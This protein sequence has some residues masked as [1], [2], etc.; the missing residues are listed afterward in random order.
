M[1]DFRFV[2][3]VLAR[4]PGFTITVVLALAIGIG[5]TTAIFSLV[6]GVLL[7][8]LPYPDS[9]RLVMVWQ[10]YTGRGGPNDEWASPGN[11]RDWRD[12]REVFS[13]LTAMTGWTPAAVFDGQQP[14]TL[15]GEQVTHT[16]FATLG[17][18]PIAG[19]DFEPTTCPTRRGWS[20]SA[21]G[22][23]RRD[24][25]AIVRSS[26]ARSRSPASRTK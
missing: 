6:N 21:T 17:L 19:R 25:A 24:S 8:P 26:A 11:V 4:T 18:P 15:T 16:Y 10:D 5:A 12:Q 13:S 23:G 3:R 22:S 2:L 7:R 1:A 14:E 20:L 9:E